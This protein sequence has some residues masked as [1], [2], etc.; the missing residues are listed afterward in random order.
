MALLGPLRVA[1]ADGTPIDIG[2]ARLRM[3]LARLALDAG[4]SVPVDVLIDGLWGDQPP[5]EAGNALQS[6]VSRLRRVLRPAGAELESGPG[7]YRLAVPADAVDVHRF[8]QLATEGR[9]ELI[10]GRDSRAAEALREA[11]DL[12]R[13]AALADV[14]DAPFAAGPARRLDDR[15]A[16]VSE[17]RFEAELRLGRHAEVL[18]DLTAAVFRHPLRERL[19]GLRIRAL[20]A[21][22]R[23]ADALLAYEATRV[24]L[25]DELGVDPSAELQDVH[26]RALRGEFAPVPTVVDRLPQ[27]LT[28]FIGR[29][30]ELKLLA[31]LLDDARLVTLVGPGG[32]GKTRLA[33]EAASRHPAHARGRV[34]FVPLAGVRDGADVLGALLTALE[35][36]EARVGETE[37][38]RRP[39]DLV[40]HAVEALSG[41]ESLLVLDNCEHV[42]DTAARL[43]DDLLLRVPGLRV[44]A[45]SREPLAITGEALCPLGPLPVPEESAL[46]GE[47]GALDSA[48]LFLD[49]AVAVRPGFRLDESTVEKVTQICRRLDGMPLALEL[50]A[51]R[52]RSMTAGQIAERL[53]DRFRLLST[54]SRT[55]LPRQRTLRAVVE[56]SWDLLTDTEL[57]LARRLAVFAS[58]FDEAAVDAVCADEQLPASEVVY[59]L[60]S[61]IEK[62][63]VDTVG[64]RYRMLETLRAYAADRL[65]ASGEGDRFRAAMVAYYLELA[66]R[67]E[68]LLRAREQITA[69]AVFET[70]NDN[71]NT[72]LRAA[73][74][75]G[76]GDSAGRLLFAMFWYLTVLG[77]SERAESFV[78]DV[79]GLGDRL[80]PYVAAS[81]KLSQVML[82]S[83]GDPQ[84]MGDVGDLVEECVRT[85]AVSR[86][87]WLAVALPVVAYVGGHPDLARREIRRS[88][89]GADAW[90][91]AAG[92]WAESFLLADAGDLAA[93]AEARERAH[94]GFAEVGDRWGLAMTYS[95]R[96]SD[97]SQHGDHDGAVAAYTEGLRLALE[98]RSHDDVVQQWW[99]LALERSR[100]GDHAGARREL[101]AAHHYAERAGS[102]Q[103]QVILL[104]GYE[105][106][107]V[108]EGEVARARELHREILDAQEKWPFPGPGFEK[109]W[110]GSY[111]AALLIAE[112]KP[113]EAETFAVGA[114][115]AAARRTDM[116]QLAEAVEVLARIRY[117]QGKLGEA[118]ENLSLAAVVCGR[119]DL[120]SP[121]IRELIENLR[122]DLD[123][124]RFEE[125]ST[126]ALRIPRA[127]AIEQLLSELDGGSGP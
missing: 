109:E 79:L 127:E 93:S 96:A 13:G 31:E 24:V 125:L 75:K 82:W 40:E 39:T 54:G 88:I 52:L 12:W 119:L 121:E 56:W 104:L 67:T 26:L 114:L 20:C 122:R 92:H 38:L 11:V 41:A 111:E 49:R 108:R 62:S 69:I 15:H 101:D 51:A 70:E 30:D 102:R 72:A 116:P 4:R 115:R 61:L 23:Q 84:Q 43:L 77:Q 34:W 112:E 25:A 36:R 95:F 35:V 53:D 19:V 64:T 66:E 59:V 14:L 27:R 6:L 126:S 58:S 110:L 60:G 55:A 80:P 73:V 21:S 22:G 68:P 90:G 97:L 106:V 16:E 83:N 3:L 99:R 100:A 10:A 74:E 8:E 81:L 29:T 42:I 9:T 50:A 91:R 2:G 78:A 85:G 18:A 103:L 107:A 71:L 63:I 57:L 118:A 32:A 120:G 76:D 65:S 5:A 105:A 98:L 33:T 47:V 48:R 7:G 124:A 1:G 45:T 113:D 94:A 28:S 37:V 89:S 117:L 44:L 17:D 123:P 86:S 46:P 87:R